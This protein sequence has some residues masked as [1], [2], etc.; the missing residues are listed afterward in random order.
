MENENN[1]YSYNMTPTNK[2]SL[3]KTTKNPFSNNLAGKSTGT[4]G[5]T[6]LGASPLPVVYPKFN[7]QVSANTMNPFK[8]L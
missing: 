3:T 6:P 4:Y 7:G 8:T 1:N 5:S 2:L